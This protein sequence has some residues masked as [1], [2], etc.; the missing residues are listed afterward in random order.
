MPFATH[1]THIPMRLLQLLLVAGL[2]VSLTACDLFERED[3][4]FDTDNP[5]LEFFPLQQSV[6]EG[7]IMSSDTTIAVE[8]QLIGE[9]RGEPLDVTFSVDDSST[10]VEGT[11]YNLPSTSATIAD[12]SSQ[13]TVPIVVLDDDQDNAGTVQVWMSLDEDNEVEP[14]ENLKTFRLDLPRTDG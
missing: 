12:S 7:N 4:T 8:I 6:E 10:A 5:K 1:T 2:I 3:R 9:Q 14:A 11:H 13:T